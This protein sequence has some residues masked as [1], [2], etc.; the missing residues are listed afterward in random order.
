MELSE[1]KPPKVFISYS[2]DSPEHQDRVLCLADRL[3]RDGIDALVDQY[4]LAPRD[5]WPLWMDLEIQK[6]DFVL[7]VCTDVYLRR[8]EHREDPGKGRGVLWEGK[9]IYN[10]LY[11]T[12]SPTQKFIPILFE[13]GDLAHI[14]HPLRTMS[15][16]S[17]DT[18]EGYGDLCRQLTDQPRHRM[19][20]LGKLRALPTKEP[21]SYPASPEARAEGKP[22]TSLDRRNRLAML[23]RVRRDWIDGVLKQSLYSVARIELGLESK[24]GYVEQPLN[25]FV[26]TLNQAPI[27]VPPGTNITNL[28]DEHGEALLILGAPGTGKSTLLL[29][30][31]ERLLD[32]AEQDDNQPMPVVFNL[33]SWALRRQPLAQWLVAELNERSDVPKK[34]AQLWVETEQIL[35]LMDGLDE[36]ALHHRQGCVEEINSFRRSYGL[37][38]IAVCSRVADYEALGTKLRLRHAVLVEPLTQV[39]V[40]DYLARGGELLEPLQTAVLEDPSLAELLETPLMLWVAILAQRNA[41]LKLAKGDSFEQGRRRLFEN[42][43]DAMF[44]RRSPETRYRKD[45][46]LGWLSWLASALVRNKQTVFYLEN[47]QLDWFS[48]RQERWFAKAEI[49]TASAAS[50]ALV[51]WLGMTGGLLALG[52]GLPAWALLNLLI[53]I[54]LSG[55]V[56]GLIGTLTGLRP[57][58]IFQFHLSNVRR[59]ARKAIRFGLLGGLLFGILFG[60]I[61]GLIIWSLG[62]PFGAFL[63]R[64]ALVCGLI[65][66]VF[67]GLLNGLVA[68]V[69]AEAVETRR[70]PNQGTRDSIKNALIIQPVAGLILGLISGLIFGLLVGLLDEDLLASLIPGLIGGAIT[71]LVV[72][73]IGGLMGGGLFAVKHW[74][75]R[76]AFWMGGSVPLR[77]TSFLD[78]AAE[79]L[80]LRKVGGGYIFVHRMLMEYIAEIGGS[81]QSNPLPSQREASR[82]SRRLVVLTIASC[83]I[84]TMIVYAFLSRH[85]AIDSAEE[86]QKRAQKHG[87]LSAEMLLQEA[88]SKTKS[89]SAPAE[90]STNFQ[91]LPEL[92]Q[93]PQQ[94]KHLIVLMLDDRSFDQ[95]LGALKSIDPRVDGLT[96]N[97][98]NPD[99]NGNAVQAQPLATVQGKLNPTPDRSFLAV[100]RQIYGGDVTP[101]RKEQMQGFVKN[102]LRRPQSKEH[103]RNVMYYFSAD[104]VPVLTTL[105]LEFAVCDRWFSSVPGPEIPNYAFADYGTSFGNVDLNVLYLNEPLKSIYERLLEHGRSAKIYQYDQTTL[106]LPHFFLTKQHPELFGTFRQF[107]ADADAGNLPYYS[108]VERDYSDDSGGE[109]KKLESNQLPSAT[110]SAD[111]FLIARIYDAI[112]KNESLWR[113]SVLVITYSSHGGFYD[114]VPPPPVTADSFVASSEK[115]GTAMNFFFDRL[116]VRVPAIIVSPYIPRGTVDHTVYEH[117]SIPATAFE[118]FLKDYSRRAR[119]ETNANAF[120]RVLTLSTPRPATDTI[121]FGIERGDGDQ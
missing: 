11:L 24:T 120:D 3:R 31:A 59:R 87:F 13:G 35:P 2:H 32:R 84:V 109:G 39:Q 20:T 42:F 65:S 46:T 111:E 41:P 62:I 81:E 50:I 60:M 88:A 71:G 33:S 29:E 96:G 118:L 117:A 28:F 54:S 4:V 103:S 43:V 93:P 78:Y 121:I 1:F 5:G 16:Y 110:L 115:T 63:L 47:L 101:S 105:A 112:R 95:M 75:L 44:K 104:K 38:P 92:A 68:L 85:V 12:D 90:G 55:L 49:I 17:V 7:L 79:R 19:P 69:T 15:Y 66:G 26:Q 108:F 25:T 76:L 102:Y 56:G 99:S 36:V 52:R 18:S 14:P 72:G 86:A 21:Q 77:Y 61:T 57:V 67:F 80:F 114:H 94:I 37:L 23:K 6:A 98:S 119:R 30:L 8:V 9:L 70:T 83:L 91:P 100:D 89:R 106:Y 10:D 113:S 97:E 48:T 27:A 58:E 45:Q 22:P 107:L 64:G 40:Q 116:G 74:V 82:V 73:S 51:V 53:F 34:T